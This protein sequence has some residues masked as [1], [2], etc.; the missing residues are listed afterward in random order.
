MPLQ[1]VVAFWECDQCG[2]EFS[3]ELDP[4]R[5]PPRKWSVFELAEDAARGAC[6]YECKEDKGRY[7][8]AVRG[9]LVL[10]GSCA[11]EFDDKED[12]VMK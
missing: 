1:R 3:V 5:V 11:R 4:A 10:C 7:G 6:C 8:S 12:E 9:G 2:T